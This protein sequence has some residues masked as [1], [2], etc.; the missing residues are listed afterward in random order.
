EP[1]WKP[2]VE[3]ETMGV[4][5]YQEYAKENFGEELPGDFLDEYYTGGRVPSWEDNR[6]H[7]WGVQKL[8]AVVA[9][10]RAV[11]IEPIKQVYPLEPRI[12]L[13]HKALAK[14]GSD[15][16]RYFGPMDIRYASNGFYGASLVERRMEGQRP[17]DMLA[18]LMTDSVFGAHLQQDASGQ[19]QVD[20]RGLA[21]YAPI[22]GYAKLG[23]R[24]AFRLEGG[25]LRTVELEYNDTV[26]DNFTDPEVDAAYAR[27]VRKGWRMAEAAFIAS[28]LS[29]T[30][31]V[32]HVKDLHLEIA[33]AFQ[34]VT[35]DAF[36]QRPKHPV[37]RLLDAFISRSVQATNDNMRLL[38]DF[39]AADFSLAPLPY[40]EQLKLIDDFIRAEPRNLADMDME[41]YGRLRHM[42]PEFSTKEAVVNSSSWGWRWHYRALT[43]QKLLVAYVD[44]FLGAEGLDAAA[45]E[46]D[47][48][49]KDWWQRMIYHLPSLRRAT[50]EN[51]DWAEV[52][53]E[54]ASLVRAVSTIML[55]VSWIHE[56]V[57]HSAAAY[58]WNPLYTPMCVPED[59]VGVPLLSWAFNAMAYR[60]FVFLHRSTLLEEAPSFWFDGNADSRQCFEDFQEALR[61][62]G[63]S[64]VAFSECEKD[65]F[66]SCVGRVETAVSS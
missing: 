63:E 37:R 29:M 31:L 22:P 5:T 54:R 15:G 62:L 57:G 12:A 60:G 43:V 65:G 2:P 39:H 7:R 45:V 20:L 49:L 59:G 56:D 3:G 26:Y 6:R 17:Q 19:F 1:R 21:K 58:V 52:E 18:M 44:C 42:D 32:M 27:N 14:I 13:D 11:G 8:A 50:E 34:A 24:A 55:W 16:F 40:Q 66:Y 47:S 23:G 33:S 9:A 30:N 41:R 4:M 53:L 10:G 61:G 36:A 38:F 35:V 48:Y 51:P 28:L 25:L 46:A 64:D